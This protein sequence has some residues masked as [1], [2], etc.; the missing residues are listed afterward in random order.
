MVSRAAAVDRLYQDRVFRGEVIATVS[1]G[2]VVYEKGAVTAAAGSG[3]FLKP[4]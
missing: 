1:R 4:Q 2:R 3:R